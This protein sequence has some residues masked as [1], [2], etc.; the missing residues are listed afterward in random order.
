MSKLIELAYNKHKDWIN[1]VKSFGCNESYAEDIVQEMYIQLHLDTQKGIDFS[2]GEDINHY[3]C[4]KLLRGIYL[5]IFKKE[6]RQIKV[7]LEDVEINYKEELG[8]D[9][10]QWSKTRKKLD[11]ILDKIYWYDKKVFEII[12]S[13]TSIAKLSRDTK[14]SYVSLYNTYRNTKNHIQNEI[15]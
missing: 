6:A 12:A 15:R 8:I 11:T 13:G 2:Y 1:I 7:Y 3:Y 14:I 5:N 4:Y 10:N 9:E